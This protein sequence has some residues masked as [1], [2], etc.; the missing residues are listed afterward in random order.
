MVLISTRLSAQAEQL[1]AAGKELAA[2]IGAQPVTQHG[3]VE[4]V[5]DRTE[6]AH[7]RGRQEL[8]FVDQHAGQRGAFVLG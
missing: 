5:D 6:L 1:R 2:E 3:N 8:R 7:L 4:L